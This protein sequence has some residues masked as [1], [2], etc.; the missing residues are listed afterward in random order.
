MIYKRFLWNIF[1]QTFSR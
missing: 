1:F